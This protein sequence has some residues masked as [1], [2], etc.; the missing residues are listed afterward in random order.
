M[1]EA[2]EDKRRNQKTRCPSIPPRESA[3]LM[4]LGGTR[5]TASDIFD[6]LM[7]NVQLNKKWV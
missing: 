2:P 5:D 3:L 1:G 4:L 6:C 7:F